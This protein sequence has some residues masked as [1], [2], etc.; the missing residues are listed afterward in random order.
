MQSVEE[1]TLTELAEGDRKRRQLR[2][3]K[4]VSYCCIRPKS[5]LNYT[6][7]HSSSHGVLFF[8][9]CNLGC[10][11]CSSQSLSCVHLNKLLYSWTVQSYK[12]TKENAMQTTHKVA[13]IRVELLSK[14]QIIIQSIG[15]P[16]KNRNAETQFLFILAGRS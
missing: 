8:S 15:V 14:S 1:K 13:I 7:S 10:S 12:T 3:P 16:S 9:G 2:R 4:K 5:I 11:A 6:A